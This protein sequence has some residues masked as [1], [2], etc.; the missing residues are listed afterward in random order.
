MLIVHYRYFEVKNKFGLILL[1]VVALLGC[2]PQSDRTVIFFGSSVCN[3]VGAEGQHGYAWL[4]GENLPKGWQY[5]NISV[6]GNNTY[7]L[8][9]RFDR[10]LTPL[11]GK[12]VVLGISL[13]NEGLHEKG[14]R[15]VLSYQENMPRLIQ[16]IQ[17]QGRI[18]I[19][20]NN[21]SRTD[22]NEVDFADLCR[23]NLEVQQWDVPTV[24]LLGNIDDGAGHWAPGFDNGDDI[25]HPNTLGHQEMASAFVP[26]MWTALE[27]GK[28]LP[29][30]IGMEVL[31]TGVHSVSFEPE[32]GLRSYTLSYISAD[33]TY[34]I[35]HSAL[36]NQTQRFANNELLDTIDE[37]AVPYHFVVKGSNLRQ[38]FLFRGA[39]TALEVCALTEGKM[40][41]SSLELY[42][43]LTG[44]DKNN[45][46]LSM[47]HVEV[48]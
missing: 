18:A 41:R 9:A 14:R 4:V 46:A 3:G 12:Y 32:E 24:N 30:R 37:E 10:D 22:F 47:N 40:L 23:V 21:Y 7:D 44:A 38:L 13:G 11:E 45:Y 5:T 48:N 42:C 6:N 1:I 39:L 15:A 43:P 26:S 19:V 28:Q 33:T 29:D 31:E 17:D 36:R 8:F 35:V 20:T 2:T 27:K 25:W 34:V 16:Q